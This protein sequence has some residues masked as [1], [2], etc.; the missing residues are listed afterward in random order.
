ML[1]RDGW[2]VARALKFTQFRDRV[3]R[4]V[5]DDHLPLYANGIPAIDVIDFD[6]PHW[7]TAQ[8]LPDKCS[9]ASLE[10][11]GKVITAWL[12]KPKPRR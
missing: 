10:A 12:N 4:A 2:T 11:V 8:D 7:H 5:S 9:A 3:G 1:V 6:Y